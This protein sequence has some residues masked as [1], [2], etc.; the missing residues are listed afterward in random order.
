MGDHMGRT[1]GIKPRLA[2]YKANALY[3][4]CYHS[5][6]PL[7]TFNLKAICILEVTQPPRISA[8]MAVQNGFLL[9]HWYLL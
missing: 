3:P 1:L 7:C 9:P 6:P 4:L 5:L 2:P 8:S